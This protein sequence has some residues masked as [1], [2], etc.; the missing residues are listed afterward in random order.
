[1]T[2]FWDQLDELSRTSDIIVDRPRGSHHPRFPDLVYP[3]D[4]GYLS[5]T[6]AGDGH[7][8]DVWLGSQNA[9]ELV[10]MICTA[11]LKKRD[12]EIKLLLGCDERDIQSVQAFLNGHGSFGCLFVR[13]EGGYHA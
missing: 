1:M 2:P 11:D 7:G 5:G 8:I 9:R 6:T 4:Y 10:G 3:L 12:T 13:R